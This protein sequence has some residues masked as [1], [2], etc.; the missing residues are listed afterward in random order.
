MSDAACASGVILSSADRCSVVETPA[1]DVSPV[2]LAIHWNLHDAL[3][4]MLVVGPRGPC[5]FLDD[6]PQLGDGDGDGDGERFNL[7][8]AQSGCM[9]HCAL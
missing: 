7:A 9:V 2:H 3:D 6:S 4:S 1:R 5:H 8:A